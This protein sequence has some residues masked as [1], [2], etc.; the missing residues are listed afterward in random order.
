MK[1]CIRRIEY[2]CPM[3]G[4]YNVAYINTKNDSETHECRHCEYEA[5]LQEILKEEL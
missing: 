1:S 4:E 2:T 3:C 5:S